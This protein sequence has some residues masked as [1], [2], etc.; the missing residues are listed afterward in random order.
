MDRMRVVRPL[1]IQD[2]DNNS[3]V[4][5]LMEEGS[6]DSAYDSCDL[7]SVIS[8]DILQEGDME[9]HDRILEWCHGEGIA[10]SPLTSVGQEDVP[11]SVYNFVT[12]V[13]FLLS[14]LLTIFL[15]LFISVILLRLPHDQSLLLC[16]LSIFLPI[17]CTLLLHR[18]LSM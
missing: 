13:N 14:A 4:W 8:F 10:G 7:L 3:T 12:A 16:A 5:S 9:A 11:R 15:L 2:D 1:L 18:N 6:G 17:P